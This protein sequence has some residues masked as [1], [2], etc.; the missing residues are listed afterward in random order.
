MQLLGLT[1]NECVR[2]VAWNVVREPERFA[3]DC[4]EGFK[5]RC[6]NAMIDEKPQAH[7]ASTS[8]SAKCLA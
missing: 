3:P 6:R 8:N 2:G 4:V 7:Q 5:D 1:D